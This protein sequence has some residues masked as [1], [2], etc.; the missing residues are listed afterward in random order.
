MRLK[1]SRVDRISG[2][3]SITSITT[4]GLHNPLHPG[5]FIVG[6]YLELFGI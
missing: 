3:C 5:E 6:T 4:N 2:S 1:V